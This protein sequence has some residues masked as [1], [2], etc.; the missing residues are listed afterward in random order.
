[1]SRGLEIG[2]ICEPST[3]PRAAGG[4]RR[5]EDLRVRAVPLSTTAQAE[6]LLEAASFEDLSEIDIL[7]PNPVCSRSPT[8]WGTVQYAQADR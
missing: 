5:D 4:R 7:L 1:M 8:A 6:A 2:A 3:S